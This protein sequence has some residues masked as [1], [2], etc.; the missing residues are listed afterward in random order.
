MEIRVIRGQIIFAYF[1]QCIKCSVV[2]L[3]H[4]YRFYYAVDRRDED[5]GY[6][7]RDQQA[8][9]DCYAYWLPAFATPPP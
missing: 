5:Q 3:F 9:Y 1:F 8:P 7:G 4:F 6:E 2:S